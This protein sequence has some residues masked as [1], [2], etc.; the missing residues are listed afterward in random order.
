MAIDREHMKAIGQGTA[1]TRGVSG[2]PKGKP[3][4]AI[5]LSTR[6]QRLLND[7]R[8]KAKIEKDGKVTEFRGAP[9]E[10]IIKAQI[11][12]ALQGDH[13]AFDNLA[14]YGYGSKLEIEEHGETKLIIETRR[15]GTDVTA[16]VTAHVTE[17]QAT[18]Q[19]VIE[20]ELVQDDSIDQ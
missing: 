11:L 8:F 18:E 3:K 17:V 1:F 10:A 6:I 9:I 15:A 16:H 20:G 2:N 5:H 19:A 13:K 7:K 14:K 12:M 4:G